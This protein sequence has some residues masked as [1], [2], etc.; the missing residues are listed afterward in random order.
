VVIKTKATSWEDPS[1]P[2]GWE[3]VDCILCGP[4]AEKALVWQDTAH[5]RILRC[6]GCGLVFRR[7]RRLEEEQTRL[8]TEEWTEARPAFYLEDYRQENLKR[9]VKWIL[10]RHPTAGAVLDIGSSYG[11]LLA[12][13]P[14]TWRL[15]GL[16]PSNRACQVARARLPEAQ[17]IHGTL[18]NAD[19]PGPIFDVITMIDTIYYLP[20]PRRDLARLPGLLKPGGILLIEAP[21]FANRGLLYRWLRHP[22]GESFLYFYTPSTL[23]KVL[24]KIGLKVTDRIDLPG[25]QTGSRK[26][27]ARVMT[28]SEY[29]MMRAIRKLSKGRWDFVPHFVLAAQAG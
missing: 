9:V 27:L 26:S 18:G 12:Q 15:F 23:G 21:N 16:E 11:N 8:F 10:N 17:I 5:S 1:L 4:E 28:W 7:P 14:A 2:A 24:E 20:Q 19:L 13:F 6:R 25:H 3:E 29:A 22:F